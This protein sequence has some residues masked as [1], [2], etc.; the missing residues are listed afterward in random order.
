VICKDNAAINCTTVQQKSLIPVNFDRSY[1][2]ASE[3]IKLSDQNY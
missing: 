2:I 3:N 1:T